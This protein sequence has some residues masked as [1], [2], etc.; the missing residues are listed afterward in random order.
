MNG[1][2]NISGRPY[3]RSCEFLCGLP[4]Y[5]EGKMVSKLKVNIEAI[6]A[7]V[8]KEVEKVLDSRKKSAKRK[9]VI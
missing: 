4:F 1:H 8:K 5:L 3:A 2:L 9:G 6:R 7:K